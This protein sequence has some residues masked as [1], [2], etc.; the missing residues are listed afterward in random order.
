[1]L[2]CTPMDTTHPTPRQSALDLSRR[3]RVVFV[4]AVGTA[5]QV[6]TRCASTDD[7]TVTTI[8]CLNANAAK[9]V[10]SLWQAVFYP[11]NEV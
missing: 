11:A 6:G 10:A 7:S 8:E 4:Q 2:A 3:G 1:V 9:A 5:V